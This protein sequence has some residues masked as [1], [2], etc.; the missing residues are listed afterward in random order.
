MYSWWKY[1]WQMK[2]RGI[3]WTNVHRRRELPRLKEQGLQVPNKPLLHYLSSLFDIYRLLFSSNF[4]PITVKRKLGWPR[5]LVPGTS[6]IL[7]LRWSIFLH[8]L[9]M[10]TCGHTCNPRRKRND[11][12]FQTGSKRKD[13]V[14][15]ATENNI[16][17]SCPYD[18]SE[19]H[20][21]HLIIKGQGCFVF[22]PVQ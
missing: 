19:K 16:K 17:E 6:G 18:S 11:V 3:H 20:H 8:I 7:L 2:N 21:V 5:L 10:C 1:E 22:L 14:R 12:S 15:K 4:I 9:N 13:C